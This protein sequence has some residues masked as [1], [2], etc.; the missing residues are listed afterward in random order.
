MNPPEILYPKGLSSLPGHRCSFLYRETAGRG[1]LREGKK[2]LV[3]SF[4]VSLEGHKHPFY[5]QTKDP[6]QFFFT[7]FQFWAYRSPF[8]QLLFYSI[9]TYQVANSYGMRYSMMVKCR[10]LS[11]QD[12]QSHPAL[13]YLR[14]VTWINC[15]ASQGLSF[16]AYYMRL[17]ILPAPQGFVKIR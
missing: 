8:L 4:E 5:C 13:T 7:S 12:L 15:A 10:S 6:F 3:H 9:D 11:S 16:L 2:L 1:Q 17:K 14:C